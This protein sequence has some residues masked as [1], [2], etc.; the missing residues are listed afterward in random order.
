MLELEFAG[1][2]EQGPVR[3][4]NEDFIAQHCPAEPDEELRKG[5]LFVVADGVG[6]NRAGEVASLEAAKCLIG[7]YYESSR[8]P[9]RALQDAFNRSNLHI[10]DLGYARPEYRRMQ[11][12]LSTLTLVD[13]RAYI[14]HVGD[15]RVYRVRGGQIEQLTNDH[16][17]VGELVRMSLITADEARHHP[18]RNIITRTVGGDL[19]LKPDFRDEQV[20]VGDIYVL[21]TDGLWEPV[22]EAE[23]AEATTACPTEEACRQLVDLALARG[24]DDNISVQAIKVL[25]L[26]SATSGPGG[27]SNGL[28]KRAFRLLGGQEQIDAG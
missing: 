11:T 27:R 4:N 16:S 15:S 20:E 21:C 25:A 14:G 1:L 12:T 3:D 26:G 19:L 10:C 8:A 13:N 17:E 5:S 24:A 18:R 6:G 23:I 22:H 28:L 2:T 7:C 9:R